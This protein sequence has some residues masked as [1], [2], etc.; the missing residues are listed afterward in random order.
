MSLRPTSDANTGVNAAGIDNGQ[1]ALV[2]LAQIV[3][4]EVARSASRMT[5][6]GL[7]CAVGAAQVGI[8]VQ[9]TG[10]SDEKSLG[11]IAA[12]AEWQSAR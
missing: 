12:A 7:T 10:P 5:S 6:A 9:L 3:E 4:N 2:A 11:L 1:F 8:L